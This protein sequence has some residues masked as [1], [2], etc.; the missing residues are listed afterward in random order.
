MSIH[1]LIVC[2]TSYHLQQTSATPQRAPEFNSVQRIGIKQYCDKPKQGKYFR[3]ANPV[4]KRF[5]FG[6][7]RFFFE[8]KN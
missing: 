4:L 6:I 5:L 3:L 8:A 7:Y 1:E 2:C